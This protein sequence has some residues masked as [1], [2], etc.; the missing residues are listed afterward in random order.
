MPVPIVS[1]RL[2]EPFDLALGEGTRECDIRHSAADQEGLFSLQW[3]ERWPAILISLAIF[4]V[5]VR[6]CSY[7]DHCEHSFKRSGF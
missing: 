1:R 7:N 3:L 2:H 5:L 4:P 6:N